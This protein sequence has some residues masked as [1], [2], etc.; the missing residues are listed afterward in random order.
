[1]NKKNGRKRIHT[2]YVEKSVQSILSSIDTFNSVHNSFKVELT[3]ILLTHAWELLGKA[4]ILKSGGKIV[5]NKSESRSIN[6]EET[7]RELKTRKE[8][9]DDQ[10][11]L[12]QQI[13]S[14]RNEAMHSILPKIDLEIQHHLFFFGCKFFKDVVSK[15]F[16]NSSQLLNDNFLSLSF[17][18][19]TTYS[20][21][22]LKLISNLRK[23]KE[24]DKRLIWLLERGVEFNNLNRYINQDEFEK[25]YIN[26]KKIQPHLSLTKHIDKSDVIRIVPIQAPKNYT[27]DV[28][29]R[30]GSD[31]QKNSLPVYIKKSNLDDDY[32][33]LTSELA[34]ELNKSTNFIAFAAADLKLKGDSKYHT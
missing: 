15:N 23:N 18:N 27:A 24:E 4:V 5:K 7:I 25:K 26:K 19:L 17:D 3:L 31:K 16:K 30:K 13:I 22:I 1:M 34:R 10:A 28:T 20:D 32:P 9:T 14:L 33:Y 6:A 29:L 2:I 12:I 8:L 21:K 11:N